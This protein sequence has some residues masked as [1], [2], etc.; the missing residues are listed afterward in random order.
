MIEGVLI[1]KRKI[2]PLLLSILLVFSWFTV[3]PV[4]ADNITDPTTGL[5]FDTSTGTITGYTGI[6]TNIVIP[7]AINGVS[8]TSIGNDAFEYCSSL[9]SVTIPSSVTSI[10]DDAFMGCTLTSITIPSSVTSIGSSAFCGCASLTSITIPSS[11]TSIG[12][13]TFA[14]CTS[15]TSVTIPNSVTSIGHDAFKGTPWLDNST[16]DFVTINGILIKYQG[17]SATI[18]IPSSVTSIGDGAFEDF[19]SLTS[20]TIPS[21]VTSVGDYAFY[22]CTSLAS[23]TIPSSVTSVGYAAFCE[24]TSLT[25]VTIPSSVT[26]IGDYAFSGCSSLISVTIPSSVTSIGDHAFYQCSSITSVIIPS[27]VTNIG[28]YAFNS[29]TSLTSVTIPSSVTSVGCN[30]F[31]GTPWLDN[32]TNNFIIINSILLEYN[33]TSDVITIPS[34]V[35]SI[36]DYAFYDCTSLTSITIPSSVTSIG[37][38]AFSQCT[39]LTSI[40]I[41]SSVTSIGDIAFSGCSSLTSINVNSANTSYSSLNGVL[42]NKLKTILIEYPCG[43]EASSYTIPSSVTSIGDCAFSLS[44][45]TSVTIQNGLTIIGYGAFSYCT[46]L[47]SITIPSSVTFIGEKFDDPSA[48]DVA[49]DGSVNLTIYGCSGSYAQSYADDYGIPFINIALTVST[50]TFSGG[51]IAAN[52]TSAVAGTTI[53]LTVTPDTGKQLKAGSL[54]YNDGSD[55]IISGT[56]FIMPVSNVTVSAVFEAVSNNPPVNNTITTDIVSIKGNLGDDAVLTV[57]PISKDSTLYGELVGSVKSDLTLTFDVIVTGTHQF[58]LT[59]S[60]DVGT[61]YNGRDVIVN[62]KLANGTINKIETN[63]VDGKVSFEVN[64]L[65]PFAIMVLPVTST[66]NSSNPKTGGSIPIAII[67]SVGL[68]S[69]GIIIISGRR[70]RI[71]KI[72]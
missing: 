53:N 32:N 39:S 44:S 16:N 30:A 10:G 11:V 52:P 12:S 21:S 20:V 4:S 3:S 72:K 34:G 45:L 46:S 17:T 56:S 13:N 5:K 1:M 6:P 50:S 61:Q 65:S 35:T 66:S 60:F 49:F 23:I 7:S 14:R 15:L 24:C 18:T 43:N 40:T 59:L 36:G 69:I 70:K 47:T 63:V 54:K 62:H 27:S 64:E 22:Q 67:G 19:T 9:T 57:T 55:H 58:P 38:Y 71:F 51:T 25:S 31:A 41:P 42:F 48:P 8:V 29:C 68:S 33:G 26:S 28:D 2:V 37:G